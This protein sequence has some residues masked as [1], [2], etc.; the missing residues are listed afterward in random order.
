MAIY[1]MYADPM[2]HKTYIQLKR[3]TEFILSLHVFSISAQ[4][5]GGVRREG[6]PPVFW[7]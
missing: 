7:G 1:R 6:G 3:G 2:I 4:F 5:G